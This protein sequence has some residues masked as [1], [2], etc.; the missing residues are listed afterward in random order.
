[1]ALTSD[2]ISVTIKCLMLKM[3]RFEACDVPDDSMK[4]EYFCQLFFRTRKRITT[5]KYKRHMDKT[6]MKSTFPQ[7]MNKELL[8]NL[9]IKG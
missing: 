6:V 9:N 4:N 1:M 3:K 5:T 7:G 8:K 2:K